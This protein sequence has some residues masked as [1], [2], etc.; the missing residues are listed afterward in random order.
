M[1]KILSLVLVAVMVLALGVAALADDVS[2]ADYQAYLVEKAGGNAPDPAEFKAQVDAIGSWDDIDLTTAPWD[3][4][5]TTVGLSTWEEFQ[6]GIVKDA[7]V[8]GTASGEP[9][10]E[11]SAEASGEAS[12]EA[13][14]EIEIT[15]DGKTVTAQ[16]EEK[17]NG[18]MET[19][20]LVITIDGT[21]YNG[22]INKGVYTAE[23]EADQ[24]IFDAVKEAREAASGEPSGEPQA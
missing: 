20:G 15:L 24:A 13:K 12:M 6:Q 11:A 17:D 16:F 2:W 4:L 9:S 21:E 1:K 3:Q 14:G 23:N 19:K 7:A 5:F 8:M 22:T 10:G 18:D